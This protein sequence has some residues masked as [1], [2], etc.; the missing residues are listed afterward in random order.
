VP[1]QQS[2]KAISISSDTIKVEI[3]LLVGGYVPPSR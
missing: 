1:G 3:A 2:T